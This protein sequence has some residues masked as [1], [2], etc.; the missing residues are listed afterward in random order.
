[1]RF[2]NKIFYD[3]K[4]VIPLIGLAGT[5]MTSCIDFDI[6]EPIKKSDPVI[7]RDIDLVFNDTTKF[8]IL[9]VD[10]LLK[11]I[12]N[13]TIRRIYL[14]PVGHWDKYDDESITALRRRLLQ[15]RIALSP[16]IRG[17]GDFDFMHGAASHVPMDSMWYVENGWTINNGNQR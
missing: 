8:D 12:N 9:D 13:D 3:I 16:K 4:H 5:T 6:R 15:Q 14:V 11:I 1:M 17:L 7:Q 2:Y 10:A